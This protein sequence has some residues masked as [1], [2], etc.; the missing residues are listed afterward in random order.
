MENL[1]AASPQRTYT[2]ME[3]DELKTIRKVLAPYDVEVKRR[4][5]L[6]AL[7][8]TSRANAYEVSRTLQK[9]GYWTIVSSEWVHVYLE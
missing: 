1:P 6:E 7:V 2:Q 5:K 9:A 8:K 4:S 3:K